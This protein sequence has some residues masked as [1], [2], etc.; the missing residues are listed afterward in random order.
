MCAGMRIEP[1][2]VAAKAGQPLARG[3]RCRRA[4]GGAA[5]NVAVLP[6]V[7]AATEER[8]VIGHA[9][10][11]FVQI[12]LADQH[13]AGLAQSRCRR[14]VEIGHEV[15]QDRGA[16]GGGDAGRAVQVLQADRHAVQ[17]AAPVPCLDLGLRLA[18]LL[19][20]KIGGDGDEGVEARLEALDAGERRL[21]EFHRRQPAVADQPPGAGDGQAVQV[22]LAHRGHS[23][24][25]RKSNSKPVTSSSYKRCMR[26]F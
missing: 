26:A 16:G 6:G 10:R 20:G 9:A 13:R 1:A 23:R 19:A 8:V 15:L 25:V 18:R 11:P 21:G 12:R 2:G 22:G 24:G 3:H 7:V 17:G 14:R 4:A 5:G